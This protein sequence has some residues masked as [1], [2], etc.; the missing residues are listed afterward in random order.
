MK[1]LIVGINSKYIHSNIGIRYLKANTSFEVDVID[2]TI[3]DDIQKI[4]NYIKLNKYE[5]IGFSTYIWNIEIIKEILLQLKNLDLTIILGGPEV[6][7]DNDYLFE[8][9]GVNFIIKNEGEKAFDRLLQYLINEDINITEIPNLYYLKNNK[10]NY[11]FSELVDIKSLV[12]PYYFEEDK[13][14]IKNKIQYVET[15]RG[16]PFKCAYCMASLDNKLR[17]FNIDNFKKDLLYLIDNGAKTIKFL[18]RTF[19]ANKKIANEV[20]NFIINL[21]NPDVS[22]QFEIVADLL[23]KEFINNL[24]KRISNQKIRFEIGIQSINELTTK[25]VNRSQDNNKLLE[26]IKLI[27]N[28]NKIDLHLD[29]IAGLP[30]EDLESFEDT[31]NN[32]FSIYPKELQLGFLKLLR[33]TKLRDQK[34]DFGYI[35]NVL[36]PYEIIQNEYLSIDDINKIKLVENALEKFYNSGFIDITIKTLITEYNLNPFMFFMNLG[37]FYEDKGY[38]WIKYQ[39]ADLYQR[40]IEYLTTMNIDIDRYTYLVKKEYLTKSNIKPK[41][42]WKVD[43]ELRNNII[44]DNINKFNFTENQLYKYS[45]LITSDNYI[46]L[47]VFHPSKIVYEFNK[48]DLKN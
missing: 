30:Y 43:K 19:N 13:E 47:V 44:R 5:L 9:Y 46:S 17:F 36:S 48:N 15:S 45:I 3:K 41:I 31:F 12:S 42:W 34:D 37:K 38:E 18:D 21:N 25:A 39:L 24:N 29:L 23:S 20:L 40:F 27:Q 4:I 35:Y 32:I 2:F 33:G 22:F 11:T 14:H 7:Y 6:S 10:I 1:T 16:C 28:S 26:N 8:N